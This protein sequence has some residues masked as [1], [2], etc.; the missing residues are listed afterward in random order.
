LATRNAQSDEP[1]FITRYGTRLKILNVYRL[2]E[3]VLKQVKIFFQNTKQFILLR[4]SL[5]IIFKK[6]D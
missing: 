5:G 4:I 3:R 2:C 6:S 1:L